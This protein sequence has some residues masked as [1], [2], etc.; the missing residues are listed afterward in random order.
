MNTFEILQQLDK[1][2]RNKSPKRLAR[3]KASLAESE[4]QQRLNALPGS[5][6]RALDRGHNPFQ[7]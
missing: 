3:L 5:V 1:A 2:R 7:P 6:K 4:Y